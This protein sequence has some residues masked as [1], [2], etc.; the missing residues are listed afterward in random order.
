MTDP[1]FPKKSRLRI[2]PLGNKAKLFAVVDYK[3]G[4]IDPGNIPTLQFLVLEDP[5][6]AATAATHRFCI[7]DIAMWRRLRDD[8][9]TVIVDLAKSQ[10]SP[11]PG[12]H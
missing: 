6:S 2:E 12:A 7:A 1:P 8:I 10:N 9:D 11:P 3:V 4:I 5:G